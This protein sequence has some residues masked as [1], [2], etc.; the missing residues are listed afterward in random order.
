MAEPVLDPNRGPRR[1]PAFL[2]APARTLL[3]A[4]AGDPSVSILWAGGR[5]ESGYAKLD[6]RAKEIPQALIAPFAPLMATI[7]TSFGVNFTGWDAYLLRFP[8]GSSVP[9]HRDPIAHG[10][11]LRFNGLVRAPMPGSGIL[12]FEDQV[13][14]LS[15]GDAVCFRPDKVTHRVSRVIGERLVLSVGCSF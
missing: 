1:F 9:P 15:E 2:P 3:A 6:L 12:R 8:E 4:L 14:E 7:R 10:E 13:F 11:H 5:Q